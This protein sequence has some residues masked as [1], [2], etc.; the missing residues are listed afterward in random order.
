MDEDRTLVAAISVDANGDEISAWSGGGRH[1]K[2][3]DRTGAIDNL[4]ERGLDPGRRFHR[5]SLR[6]ATVL[7]LSP[8]SFCIE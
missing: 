1:G 6:D 2:R 7:L 5:P 8:G 4:A 3:S